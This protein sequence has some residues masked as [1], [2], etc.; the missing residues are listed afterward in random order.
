MSLVPPD[1]TRAA[2]ASP[3][4]AMVDGQVPG[5]TRGPQRKIGVSGSRVL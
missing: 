3:L 1:W 5:G 2:P 4:A